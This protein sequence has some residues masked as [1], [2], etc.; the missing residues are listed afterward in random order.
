[1]KVTSI[2]IEL[3]KIKSLTF[4]LLECTWLLDRMSTE[5]LT[6]LPSQNSFRN[7]YFAGS[8]SDLCEQG[9]N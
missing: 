2:R 4:L 1:M 3:Q 5:S 6:L 8:R 7:Q 9:K